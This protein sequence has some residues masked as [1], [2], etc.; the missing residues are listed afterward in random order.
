MSK[1]A[2]S[3]VHIEWSSDWVR[4]TNIA[5]GQTAE[6][7]TIAGLGSILSGVRDV[8][9]GVGRRQVFLKTARLPKAAP[10]DVRRI[11]S[12][13]M[14]TIFPLPVDQLAFDFVQSQ[15]LNSEGALTLIAAMRADDLRRL[16]ADL[17]QAG[18]S[19]SRVLPIAMAAPASA[20]HM[21]ATDAVLIE[22][23]LGGLAFDVVQGGVLRLSRVVPEGSD[24]DCEAQRTLAAAKADDLKRLA[25]G[26]LDI[27]GARRGALSTLSLLHEVPQ[28]SLALSEDRENQAQQAIAGRTRV[29]ALL[30]LSAVLIFTLV[31][32]N[33]MAAQSVVDK[34]QASWA[35]QLVKYNTRKTTATDRA[36]SSTAISG[37]LHTAFSPAQPLSD[38]VGYIGDSLPHGAWLNQLTA[39]RGKAIDIRGTAMTSDEVGTFVHRLGAS[40]RF[41]DVHLVFANSAI[42]GKIPVVQFNVT[43]VSVGNL[44]M[45]APDRT[46]GAK[47]ATVKH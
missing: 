18:L 33:R 5:T 46:A 14:G 41:R 9:V 25:V 44:P 42:V 36:Q 6:A 15:D 21:G 1:K 4:A 43:A 16:R 20:A 28:F 39:E 22:N 30:I 11:L 34:A 10:D 23:G 17:Q 35:R 7:A 24:G 12:V 29:A 2:E 27:P 37:A 26:E 40:A 45:P 19:A 32:T 38:V 3:P 31:W 8:I 47:P 13:Q